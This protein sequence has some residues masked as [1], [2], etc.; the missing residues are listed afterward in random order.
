MIRSWASTRSMGRMAAIGATAALTAAIF[1]LPAKADTDPKAVV[2]TYA[3]IA[4]AKYEDSL[5]TARALEVAIDALIATPSAETLDAAKAA[6]KAA[7]IPYQQTEVYRFGN[8]I[9]DDWEGRVNAWP[10]DEGLIDY[11]DASYGTESDENGLYTANV[12][13]NTKIEIDGQEVDASSLTPEFLSETLQ[14]AGDIEANVATGYHAIEFLLW[15][16]DLNG[17]GAGAGKR[18]YTDYDKANCTGGNCERRAE[19]LKSAST[20]LVADL[21]EMVDNWKDDG[22][23]RKAL[24]DGDEKT[25]LSTILT[26]MG[27]LSYGELA[28]ERMKLGLLLHD[29]EE[30]HDCFS[31]NTHISHLY[32]A[33]GIREAY[34]GSYKRIDGSSVAGPSLSDLVKETDP[35]LDTELSGKLDATVAKM[36]AIA[37]RAEA[38]EAYDQQIGEGN[39]EGNAT[40]QAA[41][42][43]L[44]DQTKSIE[45]VVAALK[46]DAIAFEGSD[47]LDSPD[48]VFE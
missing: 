37:A 28:G 30:E 23:A 13:A 17:T 21:Q 29:P 22:E 41:I 34:L 36:E 44:V 20:L 48:K 31:D 45:R 38:G 35:A 27:S 24:N 40:V 32:D 14:E 46:L 4:L 25:G 12:I 10:L 5:T 2:K 11:V 43:A 26:G 15:G 33:V 42:D 16:Q 6:W 9:V 3:D 19:Y 7:R 1:I 47:S 18:P 39:A 8:A